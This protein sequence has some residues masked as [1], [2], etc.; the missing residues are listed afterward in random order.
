LL[1][2]VPNDSEFHWERLNS[3]ALMKKTR[4]KEERYEP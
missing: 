2:T 4:K 1:L 3:N